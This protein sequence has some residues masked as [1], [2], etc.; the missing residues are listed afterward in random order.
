MRRHVAVL[1]AAGLLG[2][3]AMAPVLAAPS[4]SPSASASA[5]KKPPRNS[6]DSTTSTSAKAAPKK[7]TTPSS[8]A[9]T[10]STGP[11][12][13]APSQDSP[14]QD[15]QSQDSPSPDAQSPDP[16]SPDPQSQGSPSQSSK[17]GAPETSHEPAPAEG[18]TQNYRAAGAGDVDV[19]RISAT[20]LKVAN[21]EANFGWTY[22]VISAQGPRV[23][24]RFLSNSTPSS[25]VHFAAQMDQ[26]GRDI[27]IRV[28]SC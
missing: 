23:T 12:Q 9:S 7:S 22:K 2:L 27:H 18:T 17:C 16:Q 26:A 1:A 13:D 15:S 24:V 14:S 8:T 3:V 25:V 10:G 28:T 19:A 6:A 4:G 21:V 11:S 5:A 20:D